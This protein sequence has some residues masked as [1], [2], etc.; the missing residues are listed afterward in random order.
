MI[1]YRPWSCHQL[2]ALQVVIITLAHHRARVFRYLIIG[3]VAWLVDIT[4]FTLSLNA[5]GTISAQLYARTLGA[6]VAFIGHK[7]LVFRESDIRPTT[8]VNQAF[9]YIALWLLSFTISTLALVG[10]IDCIG[11]HALTAKVGVEIGIVAMNFLLMRSLIF[12]PARK[13]RA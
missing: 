7:F 2:R 13:K 4:V 9:R 6:T 11:A 5:V 12:Q 3:G 8:I 10:L 1:Q